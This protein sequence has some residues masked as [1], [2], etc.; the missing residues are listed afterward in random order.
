[1]RSTIYHTL[2]LFSTYAFAQSATSS[3]AANQIESVGASVLAN[4]FSQIESALPTPIASA[5]ESALPAIESDVVTYLAS[6]ADTP[7]YTSVNDALTS[8]LPSDVLAQYTSAPADFIVSLET[9]TAY[10]TWASAIPTGVAQYLA[11]VD[12]HIHSIESA[13]V[14]KALPS[15][16]LAHGTRPTG[17]YYG[18]DGYYGYA[19][20]T[21]TG[22]FVT[23]VHPTGY[24]TSTGES[25]GSSTASGTTSPIAYANDAS[26]SSGILSIAMLAVGATAWLLI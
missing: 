13:D 23:G 22:G 15:V 14:I 21:G 11:S 24:P 1:M 16:T 18:N 12:A 2:A 26:R 6:L 8:A 5:V 17:G 9:G 3:E 19:H 4:K 7:A 20:P 10:P 25:D